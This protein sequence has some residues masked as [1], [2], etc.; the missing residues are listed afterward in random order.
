MENTGFKIDRRVN[1]ALVVKMWSGYYRQILSKN[2]SVM[3]NG[4]MIEPT[5]F[6]ASGP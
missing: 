2:E 3:P 5:N 4:G 6:T 1:Q